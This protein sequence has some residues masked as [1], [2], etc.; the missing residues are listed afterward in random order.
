MN[1]R[2]IAE[3]VER[4]RSAGYTILEN[5]F[6]RDVVERIA[7]AFK[8][9]YESHLDEIRESPNRGPMRHYIQL[10]VA[11]PF[12]VSEIH[13]DPDVLAIVKSLLGEEVQ[14]A[15]YATDTPARGSVFQDWHSDLQLYFPEDPDFCHPPLLVAVNFPFVDIVP[16]NGPFEVVEGTH[17]I[18]AHTAIKRILQGDLTSKL[19]PLNVGDVLIR[20]PRCIHRGTPNTTDIPRPVAVFS[21]ERFWSHA[22]IGHAPPLSREFYDTLSDV[23]QKMMQRIVKLDEGHRPD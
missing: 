2:T 6:S 23:E 5:Q 13:A 3:H 18:P 4:V 16:Q 15:Q 19:V 1:E 21:F 10:P 22:H 12:Y 8:P 11:E 17:R 9:I 14:F 7:D 20:D